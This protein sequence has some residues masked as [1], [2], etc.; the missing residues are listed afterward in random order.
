MGGEIL[1]SM[2]EIEAFYLTPTCPSQ[3]IFA[4]RTVKSSFRAENAWPRIQTTQFFLVT[5]H[6]STYFHHT[7]KLRRCLVLKTMP[8]DSS[9]ALSYGPASEVCTKSSKISIGLQDSPDTSLPL[10]QVSSELCV[11][12]TLQARHAWKVYLG[13]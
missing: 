4:T 6:T 1:R 7:I 9:M 11:S 5:F 10:R 3:L 8:G 13:S 2:R 12:P